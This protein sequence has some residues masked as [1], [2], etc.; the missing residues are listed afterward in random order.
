[1][2]VL[3]YK[4][5]SALRSA[6]D[7]AETLIRSLREGEIVAAD[8]KRPRNLAHHRKFWKLMQIV[9]DNQ[10][11]YKDAEEVCTA[12][13]FAVGH[14]QKLKTMR[15]VV[16]IPL[17]ISF[18][19]MDQTAFEAFYERALDFLVTEVIPGIA[20]KELEREIDDMLKPKVIA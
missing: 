12:F 11:H 5:L 4:H 13:K 20:V 14:T 3:V 19:R 15:G 7:D 6:D 16:E 18:A 10:E 17:S 2:R 9:A 1:M 8:I